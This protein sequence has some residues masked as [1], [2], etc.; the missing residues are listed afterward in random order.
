MAYKKKYALVA[1]AGIAIASGAAWWMQRQP[2]T[3]SSA[4]PA[5]SAPG[6]APAAVGVTIDQEPEPDGP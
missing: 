3:A 4:S 2:H 1:V 6:A 5:A